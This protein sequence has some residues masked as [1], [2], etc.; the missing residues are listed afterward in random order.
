MLSLNERYT[1]REHGRLVTYRFINSLVITKIVKIRNY[2]NVFFGQLSDTLRGHI[3]D[4]SWKFEFLPDEYEKDGDA[5]D[6]VGFLTCLCNADHI[7]C[8]RL[9]DGQSFANKYIAV[10]PNT[11]SNERLK[12]EFHVNSKSQR[13]AVAE[14]I[15]C[16]YDDGGVNRPQF[17]FETRNDR[18]HSPFTGG[19][20]AYNTVNRNFN[21]RSTSSTRSTR[22][23]IDQNRLS[24]DTSTGRANILKWHENREGG[25]VPITSSDSSPE[26]D[27]PS[28][29][30][31]LASNNVVEK[32]IEK[33]EA[34]N[35]ADANKI[36]KPISNDVAILDD[37]DIGGQITE[38]SIIIHEKTRIV[39][40]RD[41]ALR[42][43]E[44]LGCQ[45]SLSLEGLNL[46]AN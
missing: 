6:T 28:K 2:K 21:G 38:C 33:D 36:I 34:I 5:D 22:P 11:F 4:K 3:D 37:G 32:I 17:R 13:Q 20:T 44:T 43:I 16:N 41:L 1:L 18:H 10:K 7:E 26:R 42:V 25:A 23:T 24:F 39:T 12:R 27:P 14:W 46:K 19:S 29:R 15:N 9:L 40:R 45:T 31:R 8:I 30:P 35:L